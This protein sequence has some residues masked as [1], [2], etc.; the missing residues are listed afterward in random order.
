MQAVAKAAPDGY[1][2]LM[3]SNTLATNVTLFSNLS[4]D[5]ARDFAAVSR[6][7]NPILHRYR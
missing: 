7:R 6:L 2:L 5:P 1:T 3:A 4:L